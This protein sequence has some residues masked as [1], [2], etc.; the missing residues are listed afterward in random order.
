MGV[1]G[2]MVTSVTLLCFGSGELGDRAAL[3][4]LAFHPAAVL[5]PALWGRE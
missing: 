3:P 1:M 4:P 2:V 5:R